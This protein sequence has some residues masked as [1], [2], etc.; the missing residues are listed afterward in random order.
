MYRTERAHHS[1]LSDRDVAAEGRGVGQND[2]VADVAIVRDVGI[3]HNQYMASHASQTAA[4]DGPAV[5]GDKLANLVMVT[6]LEP[7]RFAGVGEVL[8][9]HA[10]RAKRKE[11]VV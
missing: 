2:V 3:S 4:L 8:R 1:P 5:D 10:D 11:A 6:D 7:S 9:R